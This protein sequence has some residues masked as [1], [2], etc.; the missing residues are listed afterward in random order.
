M[1]TSLVVLNNYLPIKWSTSYEVLLFLT[2]R[3]LTTCRSVCNGDPSDE[4]GF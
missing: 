4:Y 1:A 3:L 2:L